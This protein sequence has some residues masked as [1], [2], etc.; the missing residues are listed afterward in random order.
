MPIKKRALPSHFFGIST[1]DLSPNLVASDRSRMDAKHMESNH[2]S[3]TDVRYYHTP[4]ST[5][6][7]CICLHNTTVMMM[8]LSSMSSTKS[9]ENTTVSVSGSN[10]CMVPSLYQ[11]VEKLK[12]QHRRGSLYL[13]TTADV[14]ELLLQYLMFGKLPET[15]KVTIRQAK[16]LLKMIEPLDN[17]EPLLEH[18]N[19]FLAAEQE[20]KKRSKILRHRLTYISL[21]NNKSSHEDDASGS[22]GVGSNP[23]DDDAAL[24]IFGLPEDTDPT[25]SVLTN[26]NKNKSSS[27]SSSS[28]SSNNKLVDCF[29]ARHDMNTPPIVNVDVLPNLAAAISSDSSE[30]SSR[31]DQKTLVSNDGST[32]FSYSKKTHPYDHHQNCYPSLSEDFNAI[33]VET[34]TTTTTITSIPNNKKTRSLSAASSSQQSSSSSSTNTTRGYKSSLRKAYQKYQEKRVARAHAKWCASEYVM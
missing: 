30:E 26:N 5:H 3:E 31:M 18:V 4:L 7:L 12:W 21:I 24:D 32:S 9:N 1:C 19:I 25:P 14:F 2:K 28:S 29:G 16:E 11:K 10:F 17:V 13:N 15:T 6:F 23:A 22:N 8:S 27:S 20:Q 34:T 33:P